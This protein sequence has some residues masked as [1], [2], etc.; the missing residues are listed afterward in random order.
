MNTEVITG[1]PMTRKKKT[2]EGLPINRKIIDLLHS[3][4]INKLFPP[5]EHAFETGVLEGK[6]L[7]LAIPTSS[8]KTLVAE[9]CMLKTILEGKGKALYLVPLRS[10]AHEKY[11]EFKK[12]EQLGITTA[13][14]VGDY[15]SPGTR[16]HDADIIIL[17]TERA[18]SLI[19]HG[20]NWLSEVG[21]ITID[22]VHLVNDPSRG[23]TVEMVLAKLLQIIPEIQIVALSA[24]ISNAGE[25]ADWLDAELVRSDWR[26]VP[27]REGVLL[28][29][30]ILFND[31]ST[32][33]ITRARREELTD[34]VCDILDEDGQVLVFVSSRRSTVSVAKKLA[35]SVRPYV[36]KDTLTDLSRIANR[37][38]S[39][40]SVPESSKTLARVMSMGVAFHHAG[41]ANRERSQ[42]EECFKKDQ[43]K[44][45]IATPTLAAGVNLPARRVII[46][47]YH[48]FE[49]SRGNYTIPVLEYKQMA[50]RA[51]RPKYD[52]YGEAILI[53]KTEQE[54]ESLMDHYV[55]SEPESI[56]SKLASPSALR[57]HLLASV[58]AEM[59]HNR[60][61]IDG[62]ISGTFFSSQFE[63]WEIEDHISAALA[64]LENGGLLEC[65][66]HGILEATPLGR[67]AS[68]L[69]IDPYTAI[70]LR[71]A[72]SDAQTL[73]SIGVLHLICHTPD[74]PTTYVARSEIEDYEYY[75][76]GHLDDFLIDP[77]DSWAN[78]D[79]YSSFLAQVK[80]ARMLQDWL[81]E[82]SERDITEDYSVGVGDVRRYVETAGWL[83]YS[84]SEVARIIG[85]T[86]HVPVLHT[87]HS[88]MKYGVRQELLELVTL[89]G[90]GRIRGRMLYSHG[91]RAMADLYHTPL[92]EIARVP[93]IGT[94]V[95]TSIK[96]QLG[97]EVDIKSLHTQASSD[98]EGNLGPMQTL[99]EDFES[100]ND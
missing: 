58:A 37:I 4:G 93:T 81:S 2:L 28:D 62:L 88:R 99:L 54:Q 70:L 42:V 19:R 14:S 51:G 6:N 97:V 35:S 71:D 12:Y 65:N 40:E 80:T 60:D 72:L 16:L 48:R 50:G 79:N 3:F 34:V 1:V 29:G 26:P 69:Y 98:D 10:L 46:R 84:A 83:L 18:D 11:V 90:V 25:I 57:S 39:G 76:E 15:D 77:P 91:M 89:R 68:R 56:T 53:A 44:V 52:K 74:Q 27:L 75:V 66:G 22:E 64:F 21:I 23:P 43:L 5:Q 87:L 78:P 49:K 95:A 41:L 94:G 55:L 38:G 59:T 47:D 67:R 96:K 9:I 33:G 100:S 13:M 61:E 32:R 92:E 20:T 24:T 73:S 45:I 82:R 17:T 86:H 7:V 36:A 85:A 31:G 8:G 63:S 30:T